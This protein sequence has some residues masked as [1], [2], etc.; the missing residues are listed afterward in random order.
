MLKSV[1]GSTDIARLSNE[2]EPPLSCPVH[3]TNVIN[4]LTAPLSL[5]SE[6]EHF[7]VSSLCLKDVFL[8]QGR[9]HFSS[10]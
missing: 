3:P 6:Y 5:Y 1:V 8:W 7:L 9:R 2:E 10:V 4:N